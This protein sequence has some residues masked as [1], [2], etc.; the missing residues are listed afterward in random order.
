MS[1]EQALHIQYK[2]LLLKKLHLKIKK[3]IFFK[4]QINVEIYTKIILLDT[5]IIYDRRSTDEHYKLRNY[6][7]KFTKRVLHTFKMSVCKGF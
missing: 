7:Y 2:P 4:L 5:T 6:L 1:Q 3:Y